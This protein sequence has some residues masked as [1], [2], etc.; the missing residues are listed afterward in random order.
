MIRSL[1]VCQ[2]ICVRKHLGDNWTILEDFTFNVFFLNSDA[3]VGQLVD[4]VINSAFISLKMF[5]ITFAS[6]ALVIHALFRYETFLT[7][8]VENLVRVAT[9]A[10][11]LAWITSDQFLGRKLNGLVASHTNPV[12]DSAQCCKSESS[13]AVLVGPNV[14]WWLH[15]LRICFPPIIAFRHVNLHFLLSL[16]LPH[17]GGSFARS[18]LICITKTTCE[19]LLSISYCFV[20]EERIGSMLE[21]VTLTVV[22]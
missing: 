8:P 14:F 10:S 3:K 6:L 15:A 19:Y 1:F 21:L 4:L 17:I 11:V 12:F 7:S 9:F 20:F 5:Y 13:G 2:E 18:Y 16:L 22:N